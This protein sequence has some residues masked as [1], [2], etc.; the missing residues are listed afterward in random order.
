MSRLVPRILLAPCL[1][2]LLAASPALAQPSPA[3]KDRA[4]SLGHEALEAFRKNEWTA[5]HVRFAAADAVLH[6]PVFVVYMARCKRNLGDLLA[7]RDLLAR[8]TGEPL[9]DDAPEPW[10]RARADAGRELS[11]LSGRIPGLIVDLRGSAAVTVDDQP[12]PPEA[13]R[14]PIW[15]NPGSHTVRATRPGAPPASASVQ[16][17]E[18]DPP[19]KVVL[20]VALPES[21]PP[22]APPA[23]APPTRGPLLP[24]LSLIGA[25]AAGL[26]AG[27]VM[28]GVGLAKAADVKA[29]CDRVSG[30]LSCPRGLE[31]QVNLARGLQTGA[32]V[33]FVAGGVVAAAGV[34]LVIVRPGG[35]RA[36]SARVV[37]GAGSLWL[38]GTF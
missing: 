2:V 12:I 19:R 38:S 13:L 31:G 11:E 10:K 1:A 9:P 26:V 29:G 32:N 18:G 30:V 15:L 21:P 5:A 14:A 25:G 22:V 16:L 23:V 24:G 7:A 37:P 20:E 6:S 34:V 8:V 3:E 33:A 27:A 36:A 28:G 4:T 35:A 17:V